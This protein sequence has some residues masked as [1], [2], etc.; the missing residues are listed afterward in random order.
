[1]VDVLARIEG[2]NILAEL[3]LP[4]GGMTLIDEEFQKRLSGR[5]RTMD[6]SM[7]VGGSA[8]NAMLVLANLGDRPGFLGKVGRDAMGDF[9]ETECRRQGIEASLVRCDRHTGVANTFI[10][11]DGERTFG[12]CLGAAAQMSA[13]EIAA[14]RLEGYGLLHVEGYLV[15]N[16]ELIES[17]C[18]LAKSQGMMVSLDLASYNV[19]RADLAFFRHLVGQYVDIVFANEEECAAFTG[20]KQPKEALE[21][22]A[23]MARVAVVK[24]GARGACAKSGDETCMVPAHRVEAVDTTAGLLPLKKLLSSLS[25]SRSLKLLISLFLI[26]RKKSC[27]SSLSKSKL[28]LVKDFVSRLSL[29]L[30]IAMVIL[31]LVLRLIRKLLELFVVLFFVLR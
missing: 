27:K 17:V 7:A 21:E 19:V 3:S 9:F 14:A 22:M 18:S 2:E 1:M 29:L 6:T 4:K 30:V 11:P 24:L 12:T 31:V 16:H 8:C 20:G 25:P 5:M 23:G 26:L 13:D 15:Q 10:T 28:L